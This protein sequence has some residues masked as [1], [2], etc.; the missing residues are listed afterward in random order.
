M[1][2]LHVACCAV[3]APQSAPWPRAG[4][5]RVFFIC[6]YTYVPFVAPR[7]AMAVGL[8]GAV[9]N[10][11]KG[12]SGVEWR[13]GRPAGTTQLL[14]CSNAPQCL[15]RGSLKCS[16]CRMSLP[17]SAPLH[18]LTALPACVAAHLPGLA[19]ALPRGGLLEPGR[20]YSTNG[21]RD[22]YR[23]CGQV[24]RCMAAVPWVLLGSGLLRTILRSATELLCTLDPLAQCNL[25]AQ[26]PHLYCVCV[27]AQAG[28]RIFSAS[29]GAYRGNTA[30]L[31]LIR[32]LR[33]GGVLLVAAAGNGEELSSK[34]VPGSSC[35]PRLPAICW[36]LQ[37]PYSKE[38]SWPRS[39]VRGLSLALPA[40]HT[41]KRGCLLCHPSS[42]CR[43][44]GH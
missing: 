20:H 21:I 25:H 17:A 42:R 39:R 28:A 30:D 33:Q 29:Y 6:V 5:H 16:S 38:M 8:V 41:S 15:H 1:A 26:P 32:S 22:C 24:D 40:F 23:L 18:A 37:Q 27:C 7:C 4:L 35:W 11:A 3:G 14:D 12:V 44:P 2:S 36:M 43:G 34:R 19:A 13:V 9:G 10:N 31:E